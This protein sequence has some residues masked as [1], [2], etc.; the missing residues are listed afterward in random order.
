M[1]RMG[2]DQLNDCFADLFHELQC[3]K[4]DGLSGIMIW[5]LDKDGPD[6]KSLLRAIDE[7]LQ[8]D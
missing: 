7:T 6:E 1:V 4:V 5:S 8:V 3:R 2:G